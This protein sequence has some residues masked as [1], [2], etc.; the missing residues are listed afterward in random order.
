MGSI[1][2]N[3]DG[4]IALGFTVSS[5]SINPEIRYTGRQNGDPLGVMTITE[6][7]IFSSSGSQTGLSRWGDYSQMS[8]DPVDDQT[9]WYAHEYIPSN[10]SFNWRTRIA[11]FIFSAPC[12]VGIATNPNPADDAIDVPIT[13]AQ[14]S[15]TNGAGATENELWFGEAGSMTLVHSGSLINSWAIPSNLSYSTSYQWRVIEMNDT[16]DVSGPVWSFTTE[17]NPD[18]V[19]DTLFFDDF[20]SG[21]TLWTITNNGGTCDWLIFTPPYPNTY[22]LPLTSSG[23]VLSADSD[24]CGSGTTMNTTAAINGTFDFSSY[25]EMVWVEFDNDFRTIDSMMTLL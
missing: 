24:E 19:I 22:T 14:L 11:S 10:G 1:A 12:P 23:G 3:G 4:D 2:M 6:G 21:L 7:T 13:L 17:A 15:W 25:T 9:F 5:S 16:C 20:E 18:I 8:I